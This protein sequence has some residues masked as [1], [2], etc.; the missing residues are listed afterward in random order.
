MLRVANM[1]KSLCQIGEYD[2]NNF[3]LLLLWPPRPLPDAL[4]HACHIFTFLLCF[5]L[6]LCS[7]YI[8][9]AFRCFS[10]TKK[11]SCYHRRYHHELYQYANGLCAEAQTRGNL[12]LHRVGCNSLLEAMLILLPKPFHQIDYPSMMPLYLSSQQL[13]QT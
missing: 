8:C 12:F 6:Y 3:L 2:L 11:L 5:I 9:F 13:N 4:Q 10:Q 1:N 7:F